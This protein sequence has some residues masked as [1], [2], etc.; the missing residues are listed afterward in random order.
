MMVVSIF[1]T[2]QI[3]DCQLFYGDYFDNLFGEEEGVRQVGEYDFVKKEYIKP[4][5]GSVFDS[6]IKIFNKV[7]SLD[8]KYRL[9]NTVNQ[10]KFSCIFYRINNT[11]NIFMK[12]IFSS[13]SG[14]ISMSLET[15]KQFCRNNGLCIIILEKKFYYLINKQNETKSD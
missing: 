8:K 1:F 12:E 15:V 3:T 2:T 13:L 14:L 11:V 10:H 7:E 9:L 5:P 4:K 6:M